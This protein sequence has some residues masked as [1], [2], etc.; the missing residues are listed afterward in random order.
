MNGLTSSPLR[1]LASIIAFMVVVVA[2][3]TVAYMSAGWS[4]TDALYMVLLTVYTV[5]YGEV[6]PI[7]TPFLHMVTVSLIVMGC[8][9]MILVTGALVQVLTFSQIQQLLGANRVKTDINKLKDHVIVCGFGRIGVMLA[10]GLSAG[11]AAFVVLEQNEA[12]VEHAR[13]LGYLCMQAD[14]TEEA[15]LQAAGVSR[16]RTLAT[17]LPLDAANVF[18]KLSARA[19]NPELEIIARGEAPSTETKLRHAGANHV[20]LPAHIGAERI[21]EMIL[22]RET[23]HAIRDSEEMRAFDRTLQSLGL[24]MEVVTAAS[25]SPAVGMT[26]EDLKRAAEGALFV[27]QLNRRGDGP[28]LMRPDANTRVDA[29]DGLLVLGRVGGA[30]TL[31]EPGTGMRRSTR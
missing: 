1:N 19:M 25:D 28:V 6:R 16:A 11:C 27:V 18:I 7:N 20:V 30:L 29:G 13:S 12:R 3:A 14:A 15:A 23:A 26:I 24:N 9:G 8:T 2:L 10:Q 5:G 22:H 31:F 4:F 17:V 21:A